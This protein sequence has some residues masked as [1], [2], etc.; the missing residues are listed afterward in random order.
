[1]TIKPGI[2]LAKYDLNK[3]LRN[4]GI[5]HNIQDSI[6]ALEGETILHFAYRE[7][8]KKDIENCIDSIIS[9][10]QDNPRMIREIVGG[11]ILGWIE[12][13]RGITLADDI[14]NVL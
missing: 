13:Y 5:V 9:A 7:G 11:Q 1:M 12:E 10:Y 6:C 3:L 8:A 14:K 4:P 2:D